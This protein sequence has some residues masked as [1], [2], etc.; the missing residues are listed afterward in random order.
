M[1]QVYNLST[2][3]ILFYNISSTVGVLMLSSLFIEGCGQ[4]RVNQTKKLEKILSSF[5]YLFC[6]LMEYLNVLLSSWIDDGRLKYTV[7]QHFYQNFLISLIVIKIAVQVNTVLWY[8][9]KETTFFL[10]AIKA[11]QLHCV[12]VYRFLF[13]YHS[14]HKLCSCSIVWVSNLLSA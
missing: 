5:V 11:L 3:N 13:I 1:V 8:P 2:A 4:E 10:N 7:Y 9:K 12:C 6:Y 14:Y